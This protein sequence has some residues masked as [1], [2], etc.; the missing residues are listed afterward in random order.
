MWWRRKNVQKTEA[1]VLMQQAQV[2][3][4]KLIK[5]TE[6]DLERLKSSRDELEELSKQLKKLQG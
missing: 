4:N 2:L 1:E 6:E 5:N 3:M